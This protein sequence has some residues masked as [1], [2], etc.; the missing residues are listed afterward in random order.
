MQKFGTETIKKAL[1]V[2]LNL[3]K[4]INIALADDNKISFWETVGLVGKTFPLAEVI[5]N[6][7]ALV[8]ELRDLDETEKADLANWVKTQYDIP[9]D[10]VENTVH[11]AIALF[12]QMLDF[13]MD[14]VEIWGG[15]QNGKK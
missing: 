9:A 11:K 8:A 12:I 2:G 6:R 15:Q 5:N 3:A 13:A 1:S 14:M 7:K 10:K 4:G